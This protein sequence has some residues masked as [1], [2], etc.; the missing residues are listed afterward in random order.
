MPPLNTYSLTE[1]QY[2]VNYHPPLLNI[3]N[4]PQRNVH[5]LT[6]RIP[7]RIYD[8]EDYLSIHIQSNNTIKIAASTSFPSQ[9]SFASRGLYSR[10]IPAEYTPGEFD[11]LSIINLTLNCDCGDERIEPYLQAINTFIFGGQIASDLMET[12][13]TLTGAIVPMDVV[14]TDNFSGLSL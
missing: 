7:G 6:G 10:G 9:V 13:R 8:A 4:L 14:P 12:F 5:M 2:T 3:S 1:A 11:Q